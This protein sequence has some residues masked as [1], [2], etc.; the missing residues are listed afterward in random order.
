MDGDEPYG[1]EDL[2]DVIRV[3]GGEV[4]DTGVSLDEARAMVEKNVRQ[5]KA[6]LMIVHEGT[7]TEYTG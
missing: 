7:N 1:E 5:K 4:V 3:Y 2:F 6:M